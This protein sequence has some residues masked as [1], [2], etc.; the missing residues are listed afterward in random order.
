MRTAL[1]AT[2]DLI[3]DATRRLW[4]EARAWVVFAAPRGRGQQG[5]AGLEGA[6]SAHILAVEP[7]AI[8][9]LE[10]MLAVP[11][12]AASPPTPP[13]CTP[14]RPRPPRDPPLPPVLEATTQETSKIR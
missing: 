11:R 7:A 9:E 3:T 14:V 2:H 5:A 1:E 10:P 8:P 4:P 12:R 6:A 13:A